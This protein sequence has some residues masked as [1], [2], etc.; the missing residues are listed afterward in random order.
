MA[1]NNSGDG[2]KRRF[3]IAAIC[4]VL[5][6]AAVLCCVMTDKAVDEYSGAVLKTTIHARVNGC[7]YSYAAENAEVFAAV[8]DYR[9]TDSGSLSLI[10]VNSAAVNTIRA[11]L[12]AAI[13]GEVQKLR[14]ECFEMPVGNISGVG[15]LSG[16]GPRIKIKIVPLGAVECDTINNFTSVGVNQTLHRVG[17][18]FTVSFCG[19]PPF[20]G[21][22]YKSE[23]YIAICESLI[24]GEVPPVY[25][26]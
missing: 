24:A 14:Y 1:Y 16:Y 22:T 23:F 25:L 26:S 6:V 4:A 9:Y 8:C 18:R 3:I 7:I 5:A 17:L 2:M 12:E 11:G 15:I 19:A 21:T 20:N 10:T 13:N